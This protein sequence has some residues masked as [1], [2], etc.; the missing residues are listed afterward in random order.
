MVQ[1][2][3]VNTP[4]A[5]RQYDIQTKRYKPTPL[6]LFYSSLM[7]EISQQLEEWLQQAM[8]NQPLPAAAPPQPAAAEPVVHASASDETIYREMVR[9]VIYGYNSFTRR[10]HENYQEL[11]A[12]LQTIR[13]PTN[14]FRNRPTA[15]TEDR[16]AI[17]RNGNI[18]ANL[19]A[20]PATIS[21]SRRSGIVPAYVSLFTDEIQYDSSMNHSQCPISLDDFQVGESILKIRGCGHLFRREPLRRW[22]ENNSICP[23]CRMNLYEHHGLQTP[24]NTTRSTIRGNST[25]S[26]STYSGN[27]AAGNPTTANG[28]QVDWRSP[29]ISSR[30]TIDASGHVASGFAGNATVSPTY[31]TDTATALLENFIIGAFT[32]SYENDS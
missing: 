18:R 2:P 32:Y 10:S 27:V 20:N 30:M 25:A 4:R 26:L 31:D 19:H 23:V 16:Y 5:I 17:N 14:T 15:Q 1:I 7:D 11:I 12:L 29:V 3:L 21:S 13:P 24:T 6:S 9:E 22:F 8:L 28:R